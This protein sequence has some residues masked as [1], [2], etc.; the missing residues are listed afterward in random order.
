MNVN[1]QTELPIEF[2]QRALQ[3]AVSSTSLLQGATSSGLSASYSPASGPIFGILKTMK[4]EFES[5]LSQAQKDEAKAVADYKAL[6]KAKTAG[7]ASGKA[8]L[9]SLEEEHAGN[10]KALSDA[11]E[12]LDITRKQR[13]ADVKFLQ[14]LKLTCQNLDREF[15]QRSKTR[16]EETKA[17]AE[18]LSII[19]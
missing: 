14:N 13:S 1:D 12:D 5:N 8:K 18:A 7:I 9:D 11:K 15:E 10:T 2:A 19:T 16:G 4:E 6:V 3:D 17:V